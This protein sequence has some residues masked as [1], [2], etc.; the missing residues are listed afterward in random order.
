MWR[1]WEKVVG[2]KHTLTQKIN[3]GNKMR[4]ENLDYETCHNQL[5]MEEGKGNGTLFSFHQR[6]EKKTSGIYLP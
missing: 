4:N 1:Q 6:K 5:P 3:N 2:D